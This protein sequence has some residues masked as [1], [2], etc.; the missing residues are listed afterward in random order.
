MVDERELLRWAES[1]AGIART[2]LGFTEN[3]Y[4]KERFE[5]ILQVA[6]DIRARA[7]DGHPPGFQV[8]EWLKTVGRGVP[9]Y[10]T[11]K[12]AIGAVVGNDD[13]EMLLIQRA[14]SGIWLFP[15]GWAD[16]GYSAAEVAEKEVH[17]ETGMEVEVVRLISVLD[18]MRQG[19]TR[20]PLYSLVFQCRVV[21]GELKGHPL[22]VTDV[23]FFD[24][25][26]LPEPVA[27]AEQWVDHAFAAIRGEPIDVVFDPPR[28]PAWRSDEGTFLDE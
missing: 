20:M 12:V 14:D 9:G 1:L 8:D 3:L 10:V 24:Q 18:G 19:F 2:G 16:V 28:R 21:G 25:Q 6:A 7:A 27:N 11:P 13:G 17:E 5:E 23:G 4:E 15:T 22:E 26:A